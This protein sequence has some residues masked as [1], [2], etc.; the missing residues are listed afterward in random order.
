M[1]GFWEFPGG[2]RRAG[3]S[4][5]EALTRELDEELGI[6]VLEA[7]PF[8][9]LVHDYADRRVRLDVWL[10]RAFRGEISAREGQT[11]RWAGVEALAD[12]GLLEADR[13]IVEALERRAARAGPAG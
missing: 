2:K 7:E 13:P 6:A 3:E 4:R 5:L 12:I 11:C 1:A 10:V 9:D 8:V